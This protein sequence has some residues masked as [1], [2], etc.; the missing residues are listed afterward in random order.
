M[1]F[2]RR[3][4][5]S[6]VLLFLLILI[7][8][9]FLFGLQTTPGSVTW[10]AEK[11]ALS[12]KPQPIIPPTAHIV[13]FEFKKNASSFQIKDVTSKMLALKK[14]C[15]HPNTNRPY[16]RSITGGKDNSIEDL[17][18]GVSHAFIV[19]FESNEDRTYYVSDDPVHQAFKEAAG[20]YLEKAIVVDFQEGVFT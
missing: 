14:S 8:I 15:L 16:I 20:P 10:L 17:Q 4:I 9:Y 1:I 19:H 13:L 11:A 12:R 6:F 3:S 18:N 7:P 2:L 5:G